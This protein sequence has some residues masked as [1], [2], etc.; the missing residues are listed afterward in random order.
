MI[1]TAIMLAALL[2]A[3]AAGAQRSTTLQFIGNASMSADGT[4]TLRLT[5]T[6]DG[7]HANRTFVYKTNDAKYDEILH[8]MGGLKPGETRPVKPWPN[9]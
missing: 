5:S 6:A 8:H 4:V 2:W 7:Q 1:K 9:N 3:T